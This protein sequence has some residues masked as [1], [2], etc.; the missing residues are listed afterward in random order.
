MRMRHYPPSTEKTCVSRMRQYIFFHAKKHPKDMA[1]R[2]IETFLTSLALVR[3]AS[4][5]TRN[6]A[7]DAVLFLYRDALKTGIDEM[8]RSGPTNRTVFPYLVVGRIG[9]RIGIILFLRK[10]RILSSTG[11]TRYPKIAAMFQ[12]TPV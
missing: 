1:E 10:F 5:S 11:S 9:W 6:Q 3:N 8:I 4:A 2:E 7:F 12:N